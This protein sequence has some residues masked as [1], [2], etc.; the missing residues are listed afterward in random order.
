MPSTVRPRRALVALILGAALAAVM[1][2][3]PPA[4]SASH[5]HGSRTS[6]KAI[7]LHDRMR[8]LWEMHGTWT[9][10]AIVD[11]VG[12]LPDTQF[13]IGRL[14]RNQAQIGHAVEPYY[15]RAGAHRLTR[16]LKAHIRAAVAVLQA[17]KSGDAGATAQAKAAFYANGN[18]VARF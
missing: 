16:L 1:I 2:G 9:E 17:A 10:R 6:A 8:A 11:F 14:L 7:A 3:A 12:G 4:S 13:A 15:G 18:Q 5:R